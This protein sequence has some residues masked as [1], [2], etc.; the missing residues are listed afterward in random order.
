M[1][2]RP[3]AHLHRN[4]V[5]GV[6]EALSLSFG[7]D[8]YA[9]KVIERLLRSN[10]S[11]GSRDRAFVAEHTYTM[12][13]YWRLLW[14]LEGREPDL[15]RKSL[16][17]LFASYWRWKGHALPDWE[18]FNGLD[19]RPIELIEEQWP[20]AIRASFPDW[21]W[22]RGEDAFG[23]RWPS[24]AQVLN[25]P[26]PLVLRVNTL[27]CKL[28]QARERL[29]TEGV[30]SEPMPDQPDG[31][32]IEERSNVFRLES[33]KDGWFEVQ[34]GG[35]Q[36]I[37]P[38]LRAEPGMRVVDACAGAGGKSLHLAALLENK[39]QIVSLDIEAWKLEELRKRARRAG[40]DN[41]E[42]RP[43][44]SAKTIKRLENSADR[45]L[46]DVPCSG[47]GV[48]KRNPDT[49]WKLRE[50]MLGRIV[51]TQ[52]ELLDRYSTMLKKGGEMVYATC[53]ILP[54][55]NEAAVEGFALRNPEFR[56]LEMERV[57]PNNAG[58]DG[59]FMARLQRL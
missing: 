32:R 51:E 49:K 45:L 35:S 28:E 5:A 1:S 4:L 26:A 58:S 29:A 36:R 43:I 44:D 47:T 16:W 30:V 18:V 41:I 17:R 33:F 14:A 59:F 20:P 2:E 48:L 7:Q 15:S 50:D 37:A 46:L 56:L 23:E 25:T 55:E 6:L 11:W 34:D 57:E 9:D 38:Y 27:K 10:K 13:R 53:S 8:Q 52:T 12:V 22:I 31:L 19:P 21:L 42:V 40:A 39:G 3:V 54:E 24:L